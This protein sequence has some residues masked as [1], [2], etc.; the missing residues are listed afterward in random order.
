MAEE[1]VESTEVNNTE[2]SAEVTSEKTEVKDEPKISP[3][4]L[5]KNE[6]SK[7]ILK[8]ISGLFKSETKEDTTEE[9]SDDITEEETEEETEEKTKS[10][11]QTTE[12]QEKSEAEANDDDEYEEIDPVLVDAARRAGLQDDEIVSLAENDPYTLIKIRRDMVEET[13]QTKSKSDGTVNKDKDVQ[14]TLKI[15]EIVK[16][17]SEDEEEAEKYKKLLSPFV[18]EINTL[19]SELG[20]VK[21]N[22][23][24]SE[25]ESQIS[26]VRS[27]VNKANDFFDNLSK[28]FPEFG[29]TESL[30]KDASGQYLVSY[31]AVKVR[32]ALWK[33]AAGFEM[34]GMSFDDSL[35]AAQQWYKGGN[36]E[37]YAEQKLIKDLKSR[38]K[39]LSPK[40]TAKS[41][42]K[43]YASEN[44][45]KADVVKEA[46]K[47]AGV[48]VED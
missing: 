26:K 4:G 27:N 13:R 28:D 32:S 47:K 36:A 39:K 31:P 15:D 14:S 33:V 10:S 22:I 29:K 5:S 23:R 8:T 16:S 19:K 20:D 9:S 18:D 1:K 44:E 38:E 2:T 48:S 35:K 37:K 45:R 34:S 11:D 12:K 7:G 25:Q 41:T 6:P 21:G 40:K 30:P 46:K 24:E 42:V 17:L 3:S 43:V